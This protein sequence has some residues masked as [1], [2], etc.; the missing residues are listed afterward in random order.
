MKFTK[1]ALSYERQLALLKER[2]LIVERDQEALTC[3]K[4]VSYYRLSGYFLPFKDTKDHF[5]DGTTL[6]QVIALYEFD[7]K[8]RIIFLQAIERVE[9]AFRTAIT[10]ELAHA[11]GPFAH[12]NQNIYSSW[13]LKSMSIGK[14]SGFEELMTNLAKEEKRAKE[15]FAKNYRAKYTSEQHLPIWMATEL[16]SF[17]TLSMMFSGLRSATKTKIAA[18]YKLPET[19]FKN[20]IH[21]LATIRNC[22]AHHSRLWNRQLGVK[23]VIPHRWKYT[24]P[25]ADRIYCVAVML[26]HLLEVIVIQST[27]REGFIGLFDQHP[28]IDTTSM[29]FPAN[30]RDL[31]PWVKQAR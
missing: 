17:G 31:P 5:R 24:V 30:W 22:C 8:L 1:P 27:W 2:G 7:T 21:V 23:A 3:L 20:W 28:E 11:C 15:Q 16:M 18:H 26:Q 25:F 14:P 6:D 19:P 12:T 10:Y 13:F 4:R 29:G 9:V